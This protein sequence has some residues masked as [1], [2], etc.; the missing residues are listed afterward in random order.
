[1]SNPKLNFKDDSSAKKTR[2]PPKKARVEQS[3]P[4]KKKLKLDA[5]KA[6][7]KAQHLRFGK[8]EL[9]PDELSR[10]SKA[11]KREMFTAHAAR[12]AAHREIDQYEGDNVGV[13]ALSEGEKTAGNVRDI[14]KSRYA[15]K[16]KKKAKMQGKK[17]TC[18]TK[19]AAQEATA[20]QNAGASGTSEGA[21]NWLS[22]WKQR[23]EI[24]KN[25]Y[26]AAR[27]GGTA[28][29]TA[30]G[31]KAASS[32][33]SA[34]RSGVEQVVDKRVELIAAHFNEYVANEPKVSFRNGQFI[35]TDGQHTI[36]G[37]I[38]RNGGKDLPILCKVYTGMTVEQEALLFA[39]Q[40]GFS[41]PLTA[42]I[43]L[44]AKVVG[45]DAISKAFLAATNRV[46]LSL[47]YDSQQLTDYRVG[48]VGTAFRLYKQMGEP[49]YC[50]TMRLIVAAWEGKPDSFRASV[51][52]GMMHFVE[53]YHGEFSEER[54]VRALR[55]IH[56]VDIYRIGQDDPAKLRG[57]KKYVFPIYTAY[58][59]KCRK[60]AL[61]MKF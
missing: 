31:K 40:N 16:L 51:L 5:D 11:Q 50:E 26:A 38:L 19:S 20:A 59:G 60:D 37:R 34:A 14:S 43:K 44:R 61:P 42:G 45:G 52:K 13:Q 39:E 33:A 58:N 9:T 6:A 4:K 27:S 3:T 21:S 7:E 57:W 30:G 48:C 49:L 54:L 18:T 25:Y 41:A 2:S 55:S 8:A 53:L 46:G 47:N 1:M 36:E 22:R 35:V 10:L 32:S 56:P 15:R 29:Q 23:Q 17:K 12:S 28:A 24:H